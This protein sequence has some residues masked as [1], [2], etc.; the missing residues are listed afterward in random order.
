MIYNSHHITTVWLD[1]DDT[2]IDFTTNAHTSLIAMWQQ[3]PVLRNLWPDPEQWAECY[4]RHNIALWAEYNIGRISRQ[5]LRMERFRRPLCQAGLPDHNARSLSELFDP[6]YL[7]LLA[8]Q[9]TLMPGAITLLRRLR[10]AGVTIGILS[11]GF[12]EVQHRKIHTAGLDPYI[13]LVVL[14][15]DIGVN[16]PDPRIFDH[17]MRQAHDTDPTHHLMIGDN[18]QTDI[19]GAIA[20]GWNALWYHPLRAFPGVPCPKGADEITDLS[21]FILKAC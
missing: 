14:S 9:K 13:D 18:P 20:T 1:L 21:H 6:L 8:Q 7:D 19:A 3:E 17:A 10:R 5:Y 15:D 4:E 2:L 12:K 11:N 16:K